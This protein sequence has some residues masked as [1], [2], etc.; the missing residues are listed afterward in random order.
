MDLCPRF[1]RHARRAGGCSANSRSFRFALGHRR[2][3]RTYEIWSA[4]HPP[5]EKRILGGWID[6]SQHLSRREQRAAGMPPTSDFA[7]AIFAIVRTIGRRRQVRRGA[8][9]RACARRNRSRFAPRR[10]AATRSTPFLNCLS[11]SRP[12]TACSPPPRMPARSF[13]PP[14]C[15]MVCVICSRPQRNVAAG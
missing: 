11:R 7:E 5:E 14:S 3:R 6:F 13:R 10:Q 12:S 15:W 8:A 2:G 1:R 9:T 4:D